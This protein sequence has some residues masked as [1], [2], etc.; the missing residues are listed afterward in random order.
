MTTIKEQDM[1]EVLVEKGI[2]LSLC[3]LPSN[4]QHLTFSIEGLRQKYSFNI[5]LPRE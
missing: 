4:K 2:K 3:L 5:F 1:Y